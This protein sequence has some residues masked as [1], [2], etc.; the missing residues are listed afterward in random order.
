MNQDL[1]GYSEGTHTV[2]AVSRAWREDTGSGSR[3]DLLGD[4]LSR[5][6]FRHKCGPAGLATGYVARLVSHWL[7]STV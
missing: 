5:L 4:C 6:R 1:A 7:M 2:L 3:S